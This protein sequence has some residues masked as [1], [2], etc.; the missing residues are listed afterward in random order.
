P[1]GPAALAALADIALYVVTL[2]PTTSFWDASEYIAT[3]HLLGIPHPPGNALFVVLARAWS[4]VL[5]PLGIPVAVRI[6]LLA[7]ATSA[8]SAGFFFL[9][10]HRVL[11]SVLGDHRRALAGAAAAA[12]LGAT[13]FTVW[14]QS[15]VN[16][17]VYTLSVL[18]I[19]A[20]SWLGVRWRDMRDQPGSERYLL[21][22]IFLMA[23]GSTNH[24]MSVLPLPALAVLVLVSDPLAVFRPRFL[25]RAAVLVALGVSFNFFVPVRAAD[26]PVI[27]EGDA[28]CETFV[29]AATAVFSNGAAGCE[30]LAYNLARKQYGKPPVTERM[31]P[32]TSQLSNYFQYFD[33]QW[34]RGLDPSELHSPSRLPFTLL[35]LLL[36]LLGL[37][38]AWRVDRGVFAYLVVLT[39]TLTVGLVYY[40]NFK[41]GFSLAPEISDRGM[42]EVRERDYFF[43]GSFLVWG[44]L[45]G[46][47]LAWAWGALASAL[48]GAR[49]WVV[50]APVLAV[51]LVPMALNWSWASRAGDYAARDWAYN[52]L[53]SLE[54]YAVIFT[55]GDNDTFPLWYAQEVEGVRKDVTVIVGQYLF[56]P[57]YIKQ[58]QELTTPERQRP[59]DP[60]QGAGIFQ[61]PAAPPSRPI[62]ALT[63]EQMDMVGGAELAEDVTVIFPRLA[64]T[65]PKGTVLDRSAQLAISVIHDAIGERPIYFAAS[66]GLMSQLGL[67]PWGVRHGLAVKLEFRPLE[68]PQPPGIVRGSN[69]YGAEYFHLERSLKLYDE[70]YAYR[71]IR[72]RR[73]WQDRATLNIPWHFYALAAQ[74]ADVARIAGRD[75]AVV[76][77]LEDDAVMF[78]IVADGG[79]DGTPEKPAAADS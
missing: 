5:A 56:T 57:W 51:A 73:I 7:A 17:K 12:L 59:F 9:I 31:A 39:G 44:A 33:W 37:W 21:W 26:D 74:L 6:N 11:L 29:G 36:G 60:A 16:E 58:L 79:A 15:T 20:V 34:A 1:Y 18:V 8:V 13:A 75:P 14:N 67:E 72:D 78:R 27:N 52:F 32:L 19:A 76:K 77:R 10:A 45:A 3:A 35:F 46:T 53:M 40:L 43:I 22:A 64:V 54:P 24:L 28:T 63:H 41:Y 50:T 38:A 42:H 4:V 61:A 62:V 55:N 47:G 65:Y 68:G 2:A 30:A 23:L 25:G 69:E 49:R 66:A 70:V 71:G 48:A